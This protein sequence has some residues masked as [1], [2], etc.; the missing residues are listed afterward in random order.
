MQELL[1]LQQD[2]TNLLSPLT[3][4]VLVI[5]NTNQNPNHSLTKITLLSI[6]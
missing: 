4:D 1:Q 2:G 6:K 5:K 3:I